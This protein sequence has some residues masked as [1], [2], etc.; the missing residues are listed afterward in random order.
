MNRNLNIKV[1]GSY[2]SPYV[3]KVL[4]CL[5][6]K[7]LSYEI[8]PIVPFFG[9]HEFERLSPLRRIPVLVDG[10]NAI[11][12]STVICEYLEDAYPNNPL[13]PL[14]AKD[15]SRARWLEEFAD[16]RL[17]E[18]LIWHL[19][20]Q[21]VIRRFVWGLPPEEAV[22]SKAINEEIP[23]VMNYLESQLPSQGY[24]FGNL[25]VADIA[26]ASFFRNAEFARYS[27]DA[28]K[29]PITTRYVDSILNIPSFRAL[30]EF[31]SVCLK[32][33][34]EKHRDALKNAGAPIA[35]GT[36][37]TGKARPGILPL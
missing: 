6:L 14:T 8:D 18:V 27:F 3:R 24:L 25:S 21:L 12:D 23:H 19:Y 11:A 22:L 31:E 13:M 30:V 7:G 32:V 4:V 34:I 20:N 35:K 15:K 29:W 5:D 17:G 1:I 10:E 37:G 2:L 26:I 9:N 33:P 16:S 36:L 28:E